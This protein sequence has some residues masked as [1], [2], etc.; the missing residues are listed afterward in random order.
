M[1]NSYPDKK[2]HTEINNE[3][4]LSNVRYQQTLSKLQDTIDK[5]AKD[6]EDRIRII[7]DKEVENTKLRVSYC[8]H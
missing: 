2:K 7:L 1:A 6:R 8:A 4:I 3:I 5:Y